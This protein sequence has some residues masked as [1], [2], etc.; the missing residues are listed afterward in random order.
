MTVFNISF[1]IVSMA[2]FLK[3]N[4]F[5]TY[6]WVINRKRIDWPEEVNLEETWSL[7]SLYGLSNCAPR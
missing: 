5:M 4:Q 1:L 6:H 3:S 2:L 7:D